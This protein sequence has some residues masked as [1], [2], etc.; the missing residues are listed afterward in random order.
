MASAHIQRWA[1]ML[2]AYNYEIRYKPG[3]EHANNA[4]GLSRLPVSNHVTT[5]PL[6]GDVLLLLQTLQGTPVSADQIRQWTDTDPILSHI[7]RNVLSS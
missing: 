2:S 4:D 3:A 5:V 7:R 1:L 6:P